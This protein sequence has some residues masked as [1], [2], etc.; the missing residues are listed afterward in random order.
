[1]PVSGIGKL[2]SILIT[3]GLLVLSSL[4][5]AM[6]FYLDSSTSANIELIYVLTLVLIA[7]YTDGYLYGV[8]ASVVTV[9][10][11]NYFYTY[12]Y[13][14]LNF[15]LSG[16]PITFLGM[17]SITMITSA[18]ATSIKE[19][20]HIIAEREK[21]LAEAEKEKMRAT[22]LRA[23][24]HDLR[25]PLTSIIGSSSS[26]LENYDRLSPEECSSLVANIREDS[27]WLLNM[28]E[29]L[30]TVTRINNQ[31]SSVTTSLEPVEEVVSEA[32]LRVKKR[33]PEISVKV[34]VPDNLLMIPMDATLIEQVI[35]NLLENAAVHSLSDK[36]IL[37][38]IEENDSD[39]AFHVRDYGIG[40]SEQ[41][42]HTIFNGEHT[43]STQTDGHKGIGIGLSI[44]KTII[45]AH[46]GTIQAVSHPDG[47]E[48]I[49]T[50]PKEE[51]V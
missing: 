10:I 50:L 20:S 30:L 18:T 16:Y 13:L 47:V 48:F 35:I 38:F 4:V 21:M 22:L 26:Y 1:M 15:T 44:C 12:P 42:L 3:C 9:I 23:I 17:L 34:S 41:K 5:S 31:E 51:A 40:I 14:E 19:Q 36:A 45:A 25:T 33:L 29:N 8:F 46:N 28:V 6:F 49:F 43:S 27:Q 32:V 24:S 39:V 37:F 2:Q 7:R 11:V